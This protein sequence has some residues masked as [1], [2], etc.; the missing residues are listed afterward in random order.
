MN[1]LMLSLLAVG[2]TSAG[3]LCALVLRQRLPGVLGFSAGVLLGVVAFDL[4]PESLAQSRR[5]GGDGQAAL[6]ALVV[7]FVLFH[8]LGKLARRHHADG[9][10]HAHTPRAG[11]LPA[12]A[13]VAHSVFDGAGIGL[14]FQVSPAV[15]LSVALAV[16]AHDFCDGLNTVGLMLLHRHGTASAM[17]MLALDA[18]APMLGAAATFTF[19]VPPEWLVLALGFFAGVLLHIGALDIL[20]RAHARA[21]P[22]A[23]PRLTALTAAGLVFVYSMVRW[24]D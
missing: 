1:A 5:L 8:A 19:S 15:G 13:L 18:V 16:I 11:L 6:I 12:A 20:P 14:A 22:A 23:L 2:S 10:G 7:G 24:A 21:G 3:G 17:G 4:L 9:G